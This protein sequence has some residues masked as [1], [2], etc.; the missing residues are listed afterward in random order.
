MAVWLLGAWLYVCCG[1]S[2]AQASRAMTLIFALLLQAIK[3][4]A[5]FADYLPDP[6]LQV[7]RNIRAAVSALSIESVLFR[8]IC[9]PWCFA[10]Y[11]LHNLSDICPQCE[12]PR[13]RPCNEPL[14]TTCQTQH[15]PK[16]VPR[17]LYTTQSFDSW[18]EFFLSHP[19]IKALLNPLYSNLT[20]PLIMC[21]I[22]DAPAWQSLGGFTTTYGNLNFSYY[23][24][25]FN[26]L[27]N[28]IAGK[29]VSYGVIMMF[30]LNLPP[31]L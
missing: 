26:L 11:D 20:F 25:W 17:R 8:K 30:C 9:C 31:E 3:I 24:N 15:G 19:D 13:S 1:L 16:V 21:D 7:T 28:K 4:G 10:L 2:Q 23:I 29:D 27:T 14:W 12:T 18:L 5:K 6:A 22:C